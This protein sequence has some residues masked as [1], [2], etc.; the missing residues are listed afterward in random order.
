MKKILSKKYN[1]IGQEFL[2]K[3]LKL[4]MKEI[5]KLVR[6]KKRKQLS[7]VFSHTVKNMKQLLARAHPGCVMF[8]CSLA[9]KAKNYLSMGQPRLGQKLPISL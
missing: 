7:T 9:K 3:M 2:E 5:M 1:H 4:N 8:S 6:D